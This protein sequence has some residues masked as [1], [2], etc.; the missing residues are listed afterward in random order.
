MA[1]CFE[2]TKHIFDELTE[3]AMKLMDNGELFND[4][5]TIKQEADSPKDKTTALLLDMEPGLSTASTPTTITISKKD[6]GDFDMFGGD[7]D[8]T[9]VNHGSDANAIVSSSNPELVPH[10]ESDNGSVG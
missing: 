8:K 6:D 9:D 7:D 4:Q 2:G 3:D 5:E 10:D 1:R